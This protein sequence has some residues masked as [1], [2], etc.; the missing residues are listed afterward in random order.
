MSRSDEERRR[1][2]VL[3]GPALPA[4]GNGIQAHEM[5]FSPRSRQKLDQRSAVGLAEYLAQLSDLH[6]GN[7][8][9][10]IFH[11]LW[12]VDEDGDLWFSVEEVIDGSG[13]TIGIPPKSVQAR[14]LGLQKL[15]HP[16]LIGDQ[17][18]LARIGGELVYDPDDPDGSGR[19]FCLT[20]ASGRYG[21]RPGQRM[22]HLQAVASKFAENGLHFWL[23]FQT[24]RS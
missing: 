19:T 9:P 4:G 5:S 22:E 17:L 12:I 21:L 6:L 3:F 8:F 18:K 16:T 15:G 2:D 11:L 14:P 23:D 10:E 7:L 1:L 20:N 24:P 13:A